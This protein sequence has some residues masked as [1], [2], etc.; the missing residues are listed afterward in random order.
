MEKEKALPPLIK[1]SPTYK[2]FVPKKVEEKIRYL[3][4][5]FP[6]TEWSGVLFYTHTGTFEDNDL[7]IHCEDIFPMDLGTSGWTEFKM[8]EDVTAYMAENIELFRCD[9]GLCHSHHSLGAFISGQ[10]S[11]TLQLEGNDTNCFVSLIVDTRGTYVAAITRKLSLTKNITVQT[12]GM[13]YEFFGEGKKTLTA[14]TSP[15][16]TVSEETAIQYFMLDVEREEV[17]NP[18]EYLDDRFDEIEKKKESAKSVLPQK[19]IYI[20]TPSKDDDF[21]SWIHSERRKSAEAK[22][23]MYTSTNKEPT[24]FDEKTMDEMVDSS[25]WQP[26]PTIIHY[27]CCQLLT[28]SLIVNKDI[29]LKQ[30]VAKHME[31]KYKEIFEDFDEFSRWADSMVEF[32][33][34]HYNDPDVPAE[35]YDDWDLYIAR[36]SGAIMMELGEY[37]SNEYIEEYINLLSMRGYE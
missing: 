34:M 11:K 19:N 16:K 28:S 30:W 33:L 4:R 27:L 14:G 6:H 9:M 13:S 25:R 24:L 7:E 10:D 5:K 26:D 31:K 12:S 32:I 15:V 2:L 35:V 21:F 29:D 17:E 23:S 1:Q 18:L 36:V 22:E 3:I 20:E 37:S 8:T